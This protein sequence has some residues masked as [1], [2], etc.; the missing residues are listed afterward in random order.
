MY[1]TG[2]AK[3]ILDARHGEMFEGDVRMS[4]L[5]ENKRLHNEADEV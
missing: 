2:T 1:T 4:T 5:T 3:H